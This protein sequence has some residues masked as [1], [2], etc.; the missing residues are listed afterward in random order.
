MKTV[1]D[2]DLP[3]GIHHDISRRN[4]AAEPCVHIKGMGVD[5]LIS[6]ADMRILEGSIDSAATSEYE[7][8]C[9]VKKHANALMAEWK[10][11]ME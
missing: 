9:W 1:C 5:V 6:L 4:G 8:I 10:Q 7:I 11:V 3:Y 2:Y